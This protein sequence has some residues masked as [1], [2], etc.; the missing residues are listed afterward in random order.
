ML[1]S[2]PHVIR[3]HNLIC[4]AGRIATAPRRVV[5]LAHAIMQAG[6]AGLTPA[7]AA[8]VIG[9]KGNVALLYIYATKLRKALKALSATIVMHEDGRYRIEYH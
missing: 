3:E 4:R 5:D 9:I 6:D 2:V 1:H 8:K 7:H